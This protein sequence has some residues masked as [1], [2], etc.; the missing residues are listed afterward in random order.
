MRVSSFLSV[1]LRPDGL[2]EDCNG[3]GRLTEI[4]QKIKRL[5]VLFRPNN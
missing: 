2:G 5:R 3:Q 1:S 4:G